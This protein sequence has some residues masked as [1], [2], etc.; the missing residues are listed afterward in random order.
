MIVLGIVM[1]ILSAI[2]QILALSQL[3]TAHILDIDN[4]VLLV[5]W[6]L[7]FGMGL[8]GLSLL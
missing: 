2:G 1:A 3:D 4:I 7:M 8:V 5:C 6:V